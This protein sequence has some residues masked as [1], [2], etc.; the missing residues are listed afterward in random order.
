V[1]SVL[2]RFSDLDSIT[3]LADWPRLV[4]RA[5]LYES[6]AWSRFI[7]QSD[8]LVTTYVVAKHADTV[9]CVLPLYAWR[10]LPGILMHQHG[11]EI[12][13]L[14][15]LIC[16][17]R[18]TLRGAWWAGTV[19]SHTNELRLATGNVANEPDR[20]LLAATTRIANRE[21]RPLLFPHLT[22]AAAAGLLG[23]L[24]DELQLLAIDAVAYLDVGAGDFNTYLG[25]LSRN[26]RRSALHEMRR[27]ERSGYSLTIGAMPERLDV[28][29]R[30]MCEV[31]S[32]H[33]YPIDMPRVRRYLLRLANALGNQAIVIS[34]ARADLMVGF[35]LL[36]SWGT[37]LHAY[38]LGL[39][40]E[41][42]AGHDV[43]FNVGYYGPIQL[44]ATN[45][46]RRLYLGSGAL[47]VKLMRGAALE[48]RWLGVWGLVNTDRLCSAARKWNEVQRASFCRLLAEHGR[49]LR[50]GDLAMF[51]RVTAA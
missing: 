51:S 21:G 6:E 42:N 8:E 41:R 29:A 30:L 34:A 14:S 3:S 25:S 33:H 38:K 46:P 18:A 9:S 5:G 4:S 24:G 11:S 16:D 50:P 19:G 32:R 26:R 47:K 27:F 49:S 44:A 15:G 40:Y 48:T 37:E 13:V 17:I 39:D 10:S 22:S 31:L 23:V 28:M 7:A 2:Q 35:S 1:T 12:R 36:L 20:D 45:A 43:Y